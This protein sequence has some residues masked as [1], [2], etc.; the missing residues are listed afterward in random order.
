MLVLVFDLKDLRGMRVHDQVASVHVG[1]DRISHADGVLLD[2]P[3]S[4]TSD[5]DHHNLLL[6][7]P[8]TLLRYARAH[9]YT[10]SRSIQILSF[11]AN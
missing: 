2:G 1:G 10:I 11:P 3:H 9:L 8:I 6:D 5:D 4:L 7:C